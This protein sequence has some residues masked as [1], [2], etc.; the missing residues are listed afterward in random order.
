MIDAEHGWNVS[1]KPLFLGFMLAVLMTVGAYRIVAH[2]HISASMLTFTL[3]GMGVLQATIQLVFFLHLGLEAKP[4]WNM[5]MFLLMV[6][7]MIVL[8]GGTMW[9]MHNINYN[10]MP[11]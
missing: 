3:L 11:S 6:I 5:I 9:I 4:R 1:L 2:S 8:I 10:V 7:I